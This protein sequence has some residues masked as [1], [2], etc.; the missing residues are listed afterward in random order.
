[1]ILIVPLG[2]LF[3]ILLAACGQTSA[4]EQEIPPLLVPQDQVVEP[5]SEDP[6]WLR[7]QPWLKENYATY[8]DYIDE[9]KR[10]VEGGTLEARRRYSDPG[11]FYVIRELSALY[12]AL[13][14]PTSLQV[15]PIGV[16]EENGILST[17]YGKTMEN[18]KYLYVEVQFTT[19]ITPR[20]VLWSIY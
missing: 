6:Q 17:A 1:M 11:G 12:Q 14:N 5:K 4:T 20:K 8:R 13:G 18:G 19:G 2:L 15:T 7:E 9:G 16:A 10:F 3:T